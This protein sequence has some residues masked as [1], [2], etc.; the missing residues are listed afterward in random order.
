MNTREIRMQHYVELDNL[1][2]TYYDKGFISDNAIDY[3]FLHERSH[4]KP[5]GQRFR[6]FFLKPMYARRREW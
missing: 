2:R 3:D 4:Y 6:P 5:L 1:E